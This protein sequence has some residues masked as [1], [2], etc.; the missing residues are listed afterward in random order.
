M[1]ESTHNFPGRLSVAEVSG[2][3]RIEGSWLRAA[4]VA[5]LTLGVIAVGILLASLPAYALRFGGQLA[6]GTP[7][8]ASAGVRFFAAASGV[9]SLASALLSLGLSWLLFRRRFA[10]PAAMALSFFLL[11]YGVVMAGPLEGWMFYW[12]GSLEYAWL[13]Q[14]LLTGTPLI[15]LFAL[16]PNGRFEPPWMRWVVLA[17]VP[18][19]LPLFLLPFTSLSAFL[20]QPALSGFVTVWYL[21]LFGLSIYAQTYR[22]RKVSTGEERQQTRWVVFGFA[23]WFV[24]MLFSTGPFLYLNS[25][26]PG[27]PTPWWVPASELGWFLSLNIVPITFSLAIFRY[28]LW[29]LDLVI[30]RT[31]VYGA[32]TASVVVLYILVIGGLGLIFRSTESVLVPLL[33]TGLAAVLFQPLRARLQGGVNRLMYGERDD[34]AAVLARLGEHLAETGPPEAAL[35]GIVRTVAQALK[36]PYAA[37]ELGDSGEIAAAYG[38]P[39]KSP[40]R[41]PLVHQGEVVGQLVAAER[42]PG[43]AFT[44]KDR[45][46]L[47]NIARQAGAAAHAARLTADLQRSRQRLVTTREEERR[48]LR[49]DLHDGLGPTLASLTLKMDATRNVLRTDPE[50][51]EDLLDGLKEQTRQTIQ[52]IRALVYDLRPPALDDFGLVGALQAFIDGKSTGQP[53]IDL[54]VPEAL[55][56]LPAAYE[57]AIYRIVMEGVTNILRHAGADTAAVRIEIQGESL[58]LEIADDGAGMAGA[59]PAGVGLASMRERTEELGGTMVFLP[60]KQGTRLRVQLPLPED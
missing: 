42:A 37:I 5:Y 4:Q 26:P 8:M 20:A 47:E 6:H 16:F 56:P 17:S 24:Y 27:S 38:L 39:V 32:L 31:L 54:T 14:S 58:V 48:R 36:L 25:L 51:A 52:E 9:T 13:A 3:P 21:G 10:E 34:P 7:E 30:N 50:K 18:G 12:L 57:V 22:Y 55:P 33:A 23:L 1:S 45:R 15:A 28:R 46:L 41:F 53:Q 35:S 43:E 19:N 2:L 44:P 59:A 11:V 60:A 29:N 49:R 40:S